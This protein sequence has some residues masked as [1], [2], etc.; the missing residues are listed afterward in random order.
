MK[1]RAR[2]SGAM[3]SAAMV[4]TSW[5]GRFSIGFQRR[6]QLP[7]CKALQKFLTAM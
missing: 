7:D 3:R 1:V 4:S 5:S 2:S 6:P